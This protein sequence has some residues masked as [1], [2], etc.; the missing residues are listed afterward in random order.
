[1]FSRGAERR[2]GVGQGVG[3]IICHLI[4]LSVI[5]SRC[6]KLG[7]G[8]IERWLDSCIGRPRERFCNWQVPYTCQKHLLLHVTCFHVV[9]ILVGKK[10]LFER[11]S[12]LSSLICHFFWV[13][14]FIHCHSL[15]SSSN[16]QVS[17][18]PLPRSHN[19]T[20]VYRV[21]IFSDISIHKYVHLLVWIVR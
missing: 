11:G 1:M 21:Y 12:R 15:L 19:F 2:L 6:R 5:L 16:F 13:M 10:S 4:H 14:S 3:G 20:Y 7:V 18:S 17:L 8:C 9:V